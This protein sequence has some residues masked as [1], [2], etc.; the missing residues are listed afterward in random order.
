VA[1]I[2][3]SCNQLDIAQAKKG[4]HKN[5]NSKLSTIG[6]GDFIMLRK[7]DALRLMPMLNITRPSKKNRLGFSGVKRL[8]QRKRGQKTAPPI[9]GKA[10][11]L[12]VSFVVAYYADWLTL[13]LAKIPFK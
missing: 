4:M 6:L 8:G 10:A 2:K 1:S 11:L 7:L 5:C 13:V 12:S 9:R 3:G